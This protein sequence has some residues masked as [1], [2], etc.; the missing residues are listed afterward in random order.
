M[1]PITPLSSSSLSP[2]F[3]SAHTIDGDKPHVKVTNEGPTLI[4][5]CLR[6][7]EA[8]RRGSTIL[9]LDCSLSI[10][11]QKLS[12]NE[13]P[14]ITWCINYHAVVHPQIRYDIVIDSTF[15]FLD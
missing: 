10:M 4:K 6:L 9:D 12:I 7:D 14:T 1:A 3:S 2:D 8:S 13:G 11:L 5:R 15:C